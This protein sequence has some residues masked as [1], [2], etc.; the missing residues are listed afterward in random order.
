MKT[1]MLVAA[2]AAMI[3][4]Q[5]SVSAADSTPAI[6]KSVKA[7]KSLNAGQMKKVKGEYWNGSYAYTGAYSNA[8]LYGKYNVNYSTKYNV[9]YSANVQI[10]PYLYKNYYGHY[11]AALYS[12][13]GHPF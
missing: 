12:L 9:N 13:Y 10:N 1:T 5:A 4:G 3:L 7:R 11:D 2:L 6:L 8:Y